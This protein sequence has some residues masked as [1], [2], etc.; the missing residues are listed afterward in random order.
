MRKLLIILVLLFLVAILGLWR[1]GSRANSPATI[2]TEYVKALQSKD[3]KTITHLT[4]DVEREIAAIKANNPQALWE[5]L[6]AAH[7]ARLAKEAEQR[8]DDE[9][10]ACLTQG[11]SWRITK[12]EAEGNATVVYVNVTYPKIEDSPWIGGQ[13]LEAAVFQFTVTSNLVRSVT[14]LFVTRLTV[15]LMVFTTSWAQGPG[16]LKLRATAVGGTL[17]Y[18]WSSE[19]GGVKFITQDRR[20]WWGLENLGPDEA[21]FQTT[22]LSQFNPEP[23]PCLMTVTDAKGAVDHGHFIVPK[24]ETPG[25]GFYCFMRSPWVNRGVKANPEC[26]GGALLPIAQTTNN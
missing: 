23:V 24:I 6:I 14:R 25:M 12:S 13:F 11:A 7:D 18:S 17:P 16:G 20:A 3:R 5:K 26:I 8:L 2:A 9:T 21:L 22:N 19:C 15:P 10:V 4:H 1:T